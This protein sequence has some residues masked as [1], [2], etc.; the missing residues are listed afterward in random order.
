P[1]CGAPALS[2]AKTHAGNFTQGQTAAT[3][4]IVVTNIGSKSSD[5]TTVTVTDTLPAG[6]TATAI[7]STDQLWVCTLGTLSCTRSDVLA[8]GKNYPPITVTVNVAAN[9]PGLVTNTA[10]VSGGGSK[11]A[12][13]NTANDITTVIVTGPDPAIAMTNVPLVAS[14]SATYSITVTNRGL[15]TTTTTPLTVTDSLPAGLTATAAGGTGW[16]TCTVS[17][18]LVT[19]TRNDT[20]ASNQSYPPIVV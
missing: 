20:L 18:T 19:C 17:P 2:I 14:Q 13:D 4:N 5:G 1:G 9:A 7:S 8:A 10:T 3:Y 6:L 16:G 12:T 11:D 15:T